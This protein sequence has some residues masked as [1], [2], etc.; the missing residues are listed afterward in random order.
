MTGPQMERTLIIIKPD[1]V[2]RNLLG[3]IVHRFERKGLK[4]EGLK[5][6]RLDDQI[7]DEHYA[8]HKD[9]TFFESLK[10]SMKSTPVIVAVL[11]GINA[12]QACRVIVG[13]TYGVEAGAGSIRGD[14][15]M[16]IQANLVHASD[17]K[18]TA[19]E[20]IKRF[21]KSEELFE[22]IRIDFEHVYGEEDRSP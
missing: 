12:V 2:Q 14:F 11:S 16:S 5:M 9:K 15:S 6:T 7:L 17:S 10:K 13:P 22:Y 21:F 8:H 4:I 1:A 20:E 3:E 19:D 18:K